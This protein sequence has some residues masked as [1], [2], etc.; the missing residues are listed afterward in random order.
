MRADGERLAKRRGD[1]AVHMADI[2]DHKQAWA[3]VDATVKRFGRL[4]VLVNNA[5]IRR[6][7]KF[8]DMTPEEWREIMGA[9]IDGAFYCAHAA[10]PHISRPAAERS[11][12]S[13][14]YPRMLARWGACTR[15][16]RK[17][18]WWG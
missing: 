7:T 16:P 17:R 9:T 1:A 14:A 11:S 5:S 15:S 18:A 8:A 3:L 13:E 4:D 10:A 12:I 2:S 6:Q